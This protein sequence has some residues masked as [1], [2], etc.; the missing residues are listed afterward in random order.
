[1]LEV[2]VHIQ[3]KLTVDSFGMAATTLSKAASGWLLIEQRRLFFSQVARQ[4][5]SP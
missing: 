4:Q 2:C 5:S 1:M 3:A